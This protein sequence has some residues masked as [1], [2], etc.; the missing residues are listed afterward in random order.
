VTKNALN[1][2]LSRVSLSILFRPRGRI[3]V[4]Q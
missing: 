4:Y 2:L 1:R 3:G